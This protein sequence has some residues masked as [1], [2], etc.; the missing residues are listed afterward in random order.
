MAETSNQ[1]IS[2]DRLTRI[3]HA[4]WEGKKHLEKVTNPKKLK[5]GYLEIDDTIIKKLH[6][7]ELNSAGFIFSSNEGKVTFGYQ[8]VLLVWTNGKN[9]LLLTKKFTAKKEKLKS[10]S[11]L[12]CLAMLGIN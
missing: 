8:V 3:I 2:H 6:S 11:P 7:K 12:I 1:K 5:G 10:R 4:D 9:A